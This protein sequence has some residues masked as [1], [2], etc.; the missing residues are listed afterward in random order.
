M[1]TPSMGT[2]NPLTQRVVCVHHES[3]PDSTVC[4]RCGEPQR[5]STLMPNP[6]IW[7]AACA[8]HHPGTDPSVYLY[9]GARLGLPYS[10]G[11]STAAPMP[12]ALTLTVPGEKLCLWVGHAPVPVRNA[13][14]TVL[15]WLC[16]HC[17]GPC[18]P[19]PTLAEANAAA[20]GYTA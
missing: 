18:P 11:G 17:G 10:G 14:L 9:C 19:P 6:L 3:A 15:G 16:A 5:P 20:A 4:I 2:Y 12:P 8:V 13:A 7:P 1:T